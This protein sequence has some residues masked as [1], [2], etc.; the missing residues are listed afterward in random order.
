MKK[1]DWLAVCLGI[2]LILFTQR[3]LFRPGLP[4]THDS[5]N[6]LAR[7][8]SYYL[9]LKDG[10]IPPR[11]ADNLNNGFGYPVFNFN[12]PLPN[13]VAAPLIVVNLSVQ[14]SMKV[15]IFVT[16]VLGFGGI[17]LW[18]R[19]YFRVISSF[20]GS[21]YYSL[22]PY[23][24][25]LIYVRGVIGENWAYALFPWM[26]WLIDKNLVQKKNFNWFQVGL[27]VIG[28][29]F[30]LSHNIM[31]LLGSL[32]LV[33]YTMYKARKNPKDLKKILIPGL[34]AVMLS[35]FFWLPALMEKKYTVL[36]QARVNLEYSHHFLRLGQVLFSG[37]DFG[38]SRIG[39][40]DGMHMG[41]G[42]LGLLI[43][44]ISFIV[45]CRNKFRPRYL[46]YLAVFLLFII[47]STLHVT[48]RLWELVPFLSYVQFPWRMMFFA[49]LVVTIFLTYLSSYNKWVC[50][51]VMLLTLFWV[52]NLTTS[53]D[54]QR[55]DFDD[56]Y[57]L[58][59]PQT[60]SV[61]DE[62]MPKWFDKYLAYA[63]DETL[64][65]RQQYAFA[66]DNVSVF[67][68][69]A[70]SSQKIFIST[71]TATTM[72]LR[73]ANFPGWRVTIDSTVIT[74]SQSSD[75]AGIIKVDISTGQHEISWNF[76]QFTLP[77]LLGN[78]ISL[79]A[80][81]FILFISLMIIWKDYFNQSKYSAYAT[82]S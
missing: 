61:L 33:V 82:S 26:L 50:G 36:D 66:S 53:T 65:K 55:F 47:L 74:P 10:Q 14:N 31:V 78:F 68:D 40:V 19:Q 38:F 56:V 62:N 63:L 3:E 15:Q 21:L 72:M 17:Y 4:L 77:R 81:V 8:A 41:I 18:L 12:Y 37:L 67:N 16:L 80:L 57:W 5:Q 7:F 60:T 58:T 46:L 30:L 1:V 44:L 64:F 27:A 11:W 52:L 45:I 79:F 39:P 42:W 59:Y 43:L 22:S 70:K 9:A 48:R 75:N 20:M 71:P 32:V 49:P 73:I 23:V 35:M 6:H 2:V 76:T 25:S 24:L 28:G 34:L 29:M 51:V 13:I 54:E 69:L